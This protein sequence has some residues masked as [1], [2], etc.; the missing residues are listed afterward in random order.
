MFMYGLSNRIFAK[1]FCTRSTEAEDIWEEDA[2]S[3]L[4]SIFQ[5]V[6]QQDTLFVSW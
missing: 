4:Y 6:L 1:V 2:Y 5:V 3:I